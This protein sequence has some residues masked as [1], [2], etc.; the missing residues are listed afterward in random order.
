MVDYFLVNTEQ[1]HNVSKFKV[2]ANSPLSDHNCITIVIKLGSPTTPLTD[3]QSVMKT[4]YKWNSEI[5]DEYREHM[6]SNN[7]Q[8]QFAE[9]LGNINRAECGSEV[10]AAVK[11]INEIFL[12]CAESNRAHDYN[13]H[14]KKCSVV[15]VV[16]L[17]IRFLSVGQSSRSGSR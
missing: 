17:F 1:F 15:V 14:G 3:H 2:H 10:N 7:I 9:V 8:E 13:F 5:K 4:F 6:N 16:C 11:S 12:C